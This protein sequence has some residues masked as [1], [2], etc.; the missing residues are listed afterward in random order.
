M[1]IG[2]IRTEDDIA[3]TVDLDDEIVT[4][5]AGA[6]VVGRRPVSALRSGVSVNGWH[7]TPTA[8]DLDDGTHLDGGA[9]VDT[10]ALIERAARR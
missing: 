7:V 2:T 1:T 5:R 9:V 3:L 10:R 6:N 8:F 4:F